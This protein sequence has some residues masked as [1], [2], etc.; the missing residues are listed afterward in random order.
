MDEMEAN[1]TFR[2]G[3]EDVVLSS[4]EHSL[5]RHLDQRLYLLVKVGRLYGDAD[6]VLPKIVFVMK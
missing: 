1:A 6:D 3:T 4:D 5:C 2:Q